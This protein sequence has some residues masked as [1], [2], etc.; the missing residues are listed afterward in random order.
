ML[1][2]NNIG[3]PGKLADAALYL[4]TSWINYFGWIAYLGAKDSNL[5]SS[6]LEFF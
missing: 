2:V 3:D 4:D 1:P 5:M 6:S